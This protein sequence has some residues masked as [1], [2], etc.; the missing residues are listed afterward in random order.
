MTTAK[1][2][3]GDIV[4]VRLGDGE[5]FEAEIKDWS[6]RVYGIIYQ[7]TRLDTNYRDHF[8][9]CHVQGLVP[10]KP[11]KVDDR[12]KLK[13]KQMC[14]TVIHVPRLAS[15]LIEVQWDKDEIASG[16]P[17]KDLELLYSPRT[18]SD[19]HP[20]QEAMD[21]IDALRAPLIEQVEALQAQLARLNKAKGILR[22]Q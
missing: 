11:F 20:A 2:K 6:E 15:D 21:L 16:V 1:Y 10:E 8:N 18:D 9:E 17:V 12:V 5:K 3:V 22:G 19:P 4:S 13:Y 7:A 14:G